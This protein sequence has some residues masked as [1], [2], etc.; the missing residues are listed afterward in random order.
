MEFLITVL[1]ERR[2]QTDIIIYQIAFSYKL[3]FP[4]IVDPEQM[5]LTHMIDVEQFCFIEIIRKADRSRYDLSSVFR[6]DGDNARISKWDQQAKPWEKFISQ[7]FI[8]FTLVQ[9]IYDI[10]IDQKVVLFQCGSPSCEMMLIFRQMPRL[11][12]LRSKPSGR[13]LYKYN[14]ILQNTCFQVYTTEND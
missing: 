6:I 7:C 11:L 14:Y 8:G 1:I 9:R 2:V 3:G 4:Y 10:V 12:H 13:K 5:I